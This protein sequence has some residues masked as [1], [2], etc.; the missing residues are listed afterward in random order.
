M[1][2]HKSSGCYA[3]ALMSSLLLLSSFATAA[4]PTS[5]AA[6]PAAAAV[7]ATGKPSVTGLTLLEIMRAA[8][9]P[10]GDGIWAVQF[11]E[12]LS[13]A[14]WL[15]LDQDSTALAAAA[16]LISLP[17]ASKSD[18]VWAAWGA[19]ADWQTW[20]MDMRKT[21][22]D[23]RAAAK[24]KNQ[25]AMSDAADHLTEVCQSCHDKY[26]PATPTDGVVRYPFYPARVLEK[27]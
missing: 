14:E 9:Q 26:R 13:D 8:V 19:N 6:K 2:H 10:P 11:N 25:M 7:T 16:T 5:S 18:K 22:F 1:N 4:E 12:K 20:V 27:K 24:A 15:L 17:G 3:A 23:I 21:A